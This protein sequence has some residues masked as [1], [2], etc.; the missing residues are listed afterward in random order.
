MASERDDAVLETNNGRGKTPAF[1]LEFDST[2][3]RRRLHIERGAVTDA[4]RADRAAVISLL[5]EALATELACVLRHKRHALTARNLGGI[6]GKAIANELDMHA[7]EEQEHA[8]RIAARIVELGGAPD[9]DR[10][11]LATHSHSEYVARSS[12][13]EL[14]LGDLVA[15]RIAIEGY[16]E[17]VWC[18]DGLDPTARCMMETILAK[19]EDHADELT[20]WLERLAIRP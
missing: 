3:E 16:A 6:A 10:P 1:V 2:P 5:N 19:E 4:Y 8:D 12:L 7:S 9:Y 13:S 18:L 20:D 17:I 11:T 15:E 14:L